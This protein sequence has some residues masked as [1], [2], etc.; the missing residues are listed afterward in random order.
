MKLI[1]SRNRK[2]R[3]SNKLKSF[4]DK[5]FLLKKNKTNFNLDLDLKIYLKKVELN[6]KIFFKVSKIKK[7]LKQ[8]KR[9]PKG[10]MR[11]LIRK[12]TFRSDE[13][14]NRLKTS[15]K[16]QFLRRDLF[17]FCIIHFK[18]TG[19]N[20]FGT[21]TDK[22]GC[23]LATYSGGMFKGVRIRKEKRTIF[24]AQN[25]G[26]LISL[27]LYRSNAVNICLMPHLF[28]KRIRMFLRFFIKGLRV[29]KMGKIR[30]FLVKR[31]VMRNGIRL[32]KR[33]RNDFVL[34]K[35]FKN[36]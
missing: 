34:F 33:P 23:V 2:V 35:V 4:L 17:E 20:I 8:I 31:K 24:I 30:Y 29:L 1:L 10:L 5:N 16:F 28:Y 3:Y 14:I 15:I 22:K 19:S 18:Y 13:I 11:K 9:K 7:R 25:I 21:L 12:A 26:E 6:S 32:R 36:I 27:R